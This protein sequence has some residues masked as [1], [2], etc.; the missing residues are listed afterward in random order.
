LRDL[1][2]VDGQLRRVAIFV[3]RHEKET[4]FMI[5]SLSVLLV[6]FAVVL[7]PV[8]MA[9][10]A[11]TYKSKCAMCHGADGSGDTSMGKKMGLRSL[12]SEEVQAQSDAALKAIIDKGKG[13]M[14][15]YEGKIPDNEIKA[16][17]ALI[18]SFATK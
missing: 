16:L 15:G 3:D 8:V 1:Q 10:A 2:I 7:S 18:R 4:M 17:V 14:P 9:D 13:K 6:C 11:A 5:R 12:S